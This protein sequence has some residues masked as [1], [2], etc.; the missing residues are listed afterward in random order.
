[1]SGSTRTRCLTESNKW[2]AAQR[3]RWLR[4]F[5]MSLSQIYD[6]DE[7]SNPVEMKIDPEKDEAANWGR[8][9]REGCLTVLEKH[10]K[11]QGSRR[12][13]CPA[14]NVQGGSLTRL[15]AGNAWSHVCA[16]SQI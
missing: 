11:L 2:P 16:N 10:I 12:C 4:T 1:M 15:T 13:S 3:I 7:G 5:A 14:R 8:R 9:W 6:T